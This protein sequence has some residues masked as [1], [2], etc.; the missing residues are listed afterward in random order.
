MIQYV[1]ARKFP[2]SFARYIVWPVVFGAAGMIP[3]A[4]LYYLWQY[5]IVG[6]IFNYWIRRRYLGWWT[7]YNYAL[8]GALD[9]GTAICIVLVGLALGLGNANFPDW[10]GNT[11]IN[12]T[13]DAQDLA[14]TKPFDMDTSQPIG[15]STW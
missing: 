7:Q 9:I 8:S 4:T 6:L 12:N 2:R 14:V 13:L 11:V 3:P 5:V 15:P 10:W 1:V